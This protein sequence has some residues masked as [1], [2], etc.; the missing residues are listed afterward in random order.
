MIVTSVNI[1][2]PELGT[3]YIALVNARVIIVRSP[4]WIV[5]NTASPKLLVFEVPGSEFFKC[6]NIKLSIYTKKYCV[7][8]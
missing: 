4:I 5:I 8:Q 6:P 7:D 2:Q 1:K 3:K